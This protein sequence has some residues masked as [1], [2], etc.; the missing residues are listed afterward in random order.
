MDPQPRRFPGGPRERCLALVAR[1]RVWGS[2]RRLEGAAW[3]G[4]RKGFADDGDGGP[5][6]AEV[7]HTLPT[8]AGACPKVPDDAGLRETRGRRRVLRDGGARRLETG[9]AGIQAP[10]E[11]ALPQGL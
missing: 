2:G 6:G 10:W 5:D 3:E 1:R 4:L 8:A 11:W 7:A 9:S